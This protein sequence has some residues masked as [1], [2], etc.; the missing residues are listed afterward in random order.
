MLM[1]VGIRREQEIV[2]KKIDL[3]FFDP[4]EVS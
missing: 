3:D 2:L 1:H 4:N